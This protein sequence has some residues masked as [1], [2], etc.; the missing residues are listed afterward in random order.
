AR[1]PELPR[2]QQ[3]ERS[4]QPRDGELRREPEPGDQLIATVARSEKAPR[5]G[6]LFLLLALH[7]EHFGEEG[8]AVRHLVDQLRGGFARAVA[9]L[10][11]DA[12]QDRRGA[13][14]RVLQR[15]RELE[16]VRREYAVVVIARRDQRRGIVLA[17]AQVVVRRVGDQV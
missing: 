7:L 14:L 9:G 10:R 3:P 1:Q 8:V 13:A 5:N 4:L 6:C 17:F 2:R 11:L 16:R 15:G 12:Q